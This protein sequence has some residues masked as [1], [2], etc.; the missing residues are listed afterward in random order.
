MTLR[1]KSTADTTTPTPLVQSGETRPKRPLN[2]YM[3]FTKERRSKIMSELQ[4]EASKRWTEFSEEAKRPY[5]ENYETAKERWQ[6]ERA[7]MKAQ[8]EAMEEEGKRGEGEKPRYT[9]LHLFCSEVQIPGATASDFLTMAYKMWNDLTPEEK[10]ACHERARKI[11]EK[12]QADLLA[13]TMKKI[14]SGKS[15]RPA[16]V[17]MQFRNKFLSVGLKEANKE[18][19]KEWSELSE[20]ERGKYVK[21]YEEERKLYNAQKEE[22]RAG[23]KYAENKRKMTVLRAKIKEIEEEMNKPKL[24]AG[25]SHRLF[26][27]DKKDS[28][29]GKNVGER[30]KIAS[31]M[32]DAL[33]EEEQMEYKE[34]WSKLNADWQTDVAEW[35]KRN[36]DNP[37][38][39]E[40]KGYKKM[41]ETAK[42]RRSF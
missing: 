7:Q 19:K 37:K 24:F 17:H 33:T 16:D 14:K 41:L 6:V 31:E 30:S 5:M 27:M 11:N 38:M 25:D 1:L 32:W 13:A 23:D 8:F 39:T 20:E 15:G 40:L 42:K 9:G 21:L 29:K 26:K 3:R 35:E 12:G 2:P 4:K 36:A 28:M 10:E 22:Y 34:K 18:W